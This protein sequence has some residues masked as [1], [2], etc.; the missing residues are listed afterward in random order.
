MGSVIQAL[1]S[2]DRLPTRWTGP[3]LLCDEVL[4]SLDETSQSYVITNACQH[5]ESELKAWLDSDISSA[6]EQETSINAAVQLLRSAKSPLICGLTDQSVEAQYA[7]IRLAKA[8]N[9]VADWTLGNGPY[10]FHRALQTCGEVSCTYG[11]VT[12]RCDLAIFWPGDLEQRHSTFV[13]RFLGKQTKVVSID[14]GRKQQSN[15]LRWL[16]AGLTNVQQ[17]QVNVELDKT[18]Q[19]QLTELKKQMDS[20][21]YPVILIDDSIA[22]TIGNAGVLS[23][24]RFVRVQNDVNHCRLVHLGSSNVAGIKMVISALAGAPF[25]VGFR[26]NKPLYRGR[27]YA[28]ESMLL[29][30]KSNPRAD[31]MCLIGSPEQLPENVPSDI[32]KIWI[33]DQSF[34]RENINFQA[35]V[36]L[37][38][39]RWGLEVCGEGC[40][41]DGVPVFRDALRPGSLPSVENLIEDMRG[42]L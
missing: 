4:V 31:L 9:A 12:E 10:A 15:A 16:R 42:A 5:C 8:A 34:R 13:N 32:K 3:C 27:E 22:H 30:S 19:S 29:D 33:C 26:N 38:A 36:V 18:F 28:V 14:W 21:K 37:E 23:L 24:H 17:E 1:I 20:A 39:S 6:S 35:D 2:Q 40:R 25:G 41:A 7:A 11:E